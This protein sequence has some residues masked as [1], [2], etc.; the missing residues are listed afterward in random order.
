VTLSDPKRARTFVAESYAKYGPEV[1][2]YLHRRVRNSQDVRDLFQ[3]VWRRLLRIRN[4]ADVV[5]PLAYIHEAAKNVVREYHMLRRRDRVS[6][7]SEAVEYAAEHPHYVA[8]D[9]MAEDLARKAELQRVLA[10]LPKTQ[11]Q[12]LLMRITEGLSYEEIGERLGLTAYTA[13]Q[14]FCRAMRRLADRKREP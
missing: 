12:I 3:E 11:R 9:E 6:V 8:P 10:S 4:P 1:A 2:R 13:G 5:E 7:D 14:Y